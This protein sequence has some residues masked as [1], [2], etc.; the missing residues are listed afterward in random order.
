MTKLDTNISIE[1]KQ[2]YCDDAI[3]GEEEE[4]GVVLPSSHVYT[5]G[6]PSTSSIAPLITKLDTNISIGK[7]PS[8]CDDAITG[9]EEGEGVVLPSFCVYTHGRPSTSSIAPLIT[10]LDTNVS[11][12]E[13]QSCCDDIITGQEE[14]DGVVMPSAH[15]HTN[16]IPY[17]SVLASIASLDTNSSTEETQSCCDDA[18]TGQEEGEGV[19]FVKFPRE[20]ELSDF[21]HDDDT[22]SINTNCRLSYLLEQSVVS[23]IFESSDS[24]NDDVYFETPI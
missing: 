22:S 7:K 14:G 11:I 4:E 18:I 3:T 15:V 20:Q 24:L 17:S 13:T 1:E 9:Q 19:I 5:H 8:C 10:M 21:I 2:S 16:G 12:E 6:R 23:F